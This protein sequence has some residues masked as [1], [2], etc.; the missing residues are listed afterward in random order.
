MTNSVN[1]NNISLNNVD[2]NTLS[3]DHY[4]IILTKADL[5]EWIEK[6]QLAKCFAF[7]TKTDSHDALSANL[8]G[9]S[10]AIKEGKAAYL[11]LGHDYFDAPQQLS[12]KEALSAIKPLLVDENIQKISHNLKFGYSV[13]ANHHIELKNIAFDTMLESY[14]LNSVSNLGRHDLASLAQ[15]HLN[16][17]TTTLEEITGKGKNRLTFNQIPLK[18]ASTYAAKDVVVTLFLHKTLWP[19]LEIESKLKDIFQQIEMPLVSVLARME[20]VGVL[21]DANKLIKQSKEIEN[22]LVEIEKEAHSI[23]KQEFNLASPKQLQVI[24]FKKL[25]LPIVKKTPSGLPSTNEK[26]LEELAFRH[27]LPKIILQHRS[28]SKLK[29]TYTDKLPRM[30]HP[31]TKKIHTSYHQ[32]ITTTGRL[33]SRNPNLQNIPVRTKEGRRIR[34]A[35]IARKGYKIVAADYSQIELRIIAHLSQDKRLLDAFT[36]EQDIHRATAAEIFGVLLT[37]VTNAQRHSAKAI[38]F[39]LI[40]GISAFGLSRQ[41][42][43]TYA[44]AQNYI[45]RYFERYP[46]VLSYMERIRKQAT[47]QGYVETLTGRRLYLPEINSCNVIRRKASE[48]EAINAPMQGTGADI[49]KKAM[50]ELDKWIETVK[51]DLYMLMQV[52]DE[53]VFEVKVSA[54]ERSKQKIRQLMEQSIQ[55]T[56][57]LKVHIGIGDNWNEAH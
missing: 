12:L 40:Y 32:A 34:Q 37:E 49:I 31:K 54:I 6:L 15:Q 46:G 43:I 39:S 17:K 23:T 57:P 56:V 9:L 26:V 28:L 41:L 36:K 42:G 44:L 20:R 47:D 25:Q 1:A 30:L 14:I 18:Q 52:H 55:L 29:S 45:D 8:I 38:N 2:I 4:Q 21:I 16:Y 3:M 50:I 11:P 24:L 22:R 5:I 7:D 35:F 10:F 13:M 53:L 51:P 19:K 33:S 48:R 27:K